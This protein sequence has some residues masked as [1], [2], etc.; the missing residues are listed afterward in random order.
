LR[1]A[2]RRGEIDRQTNGV[3]YDTPLRD[4]RWHRFEPR[5]PGGYDDQERDIWQAIAQ[6]EAG[7]NPAVQPHP[8][9]DF[10]ESN[11]RRFLDLLEVR[12]LQP[13]TDHITEGL[14]AADEGQPASD[15]QLKDW[16]DEKRAAYFARR[17]SVD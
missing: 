8:A 7:Y 12:Y 11:L 13:W 5:G 4:Y 10:P 14:W 15:E 1:I 2:E 9:S 6:Y 17:G 16:P 3:A